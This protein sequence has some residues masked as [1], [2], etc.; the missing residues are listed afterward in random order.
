MVPEARVV[1]GVISKALG[2][3]GEVFV[4]PDPDIA[5]EFSAGEVFELADGRQLVVASA[6]SHSGR[7]VMRFEG[8]D[9]REA[10]ED[11]RGTVLDIPRD[12]VSLDQDAF[13]NDDLLGRE[14]VDDSGA[15]VGVLESTLDGAAHDYFVIA[16]PDGGDV[17]VPAVADLVEVREDRIVV[18]AIPGLLDDQAL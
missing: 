15:L 12:A 13:W 18:H 6:R 2:L 3:K 17:L 5:H 7:Q 10:A 1:V 4:R 11:L 16:R 14:V 9:T 8:V